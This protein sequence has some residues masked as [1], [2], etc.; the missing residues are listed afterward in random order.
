MKLVKPSKPSR[1]ERHEIT[2]DERI[3]CHLLGTQV[4]YT[5]GTWDKK[6]AREHSTVT[7]LSDKEAAQVWRLFKRYRRQITHPEKERLLAFAETHAAPELRR[8]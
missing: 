5:P 2:P 3:A 7:A 1:V 4:T 8:K 6:F